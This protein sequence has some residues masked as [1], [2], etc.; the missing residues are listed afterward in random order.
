[1]Y[2]VKNIRGPILAYNFG[3]EFDY[4]I[5]VLNTVCSCI[6]LESTLWEM[7]VAILGLLL[8]ASM[9]Q[10]WYLNYNYYMKQ[11]Y[12][13]IIVTMILYQS[14]QMSHFNHLLTDIKGMHKLLTASV[15]HLTSAL[16]YYYYSTLI[17]IQVVETDQIFSRKKCIVSVIPEMHL[18]RY[19]LNNCSKLVLPCA[20]EEFRSC[21]I[22]VL[23]RQYQL[24][25]IIL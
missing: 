14:M 22:F 13:I 12:F 6:N 1:M 5:H 2:S 25:D 18:S 7:F 24:H 23:F 17:S 21:L 9:C 20:I 3:Q 10:I 11:N 8:Y 15:N 19:V 4:V 16:H